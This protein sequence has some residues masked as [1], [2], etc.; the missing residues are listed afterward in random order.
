MKRLHILQLSSHDIA[1]GAERVAYE[2]HQ[3]YGRRGHLSTLAVGQRR[4]KGNTVLEIPND[5]YR[6]KW[7]RAWLWPS[8]ALMPYQS[9]VRGA[10]RLQ[11][12]LFSIGQPKR[13]LQGF[14]GHEDFD[15]PATE[16][17]LG[18]F[19]SKPDV[20]HC[21]NLHGGYFDLRKL[22]DLNREIPIVMTLH[23]TWLLSG[24]CAYSFD[25]G[26]WE[27]GCG[28]C[29]DLTIY[30][31]LKRDATAFNWQRKKDIYRQ[32]RFYLAADSH[33][34]MEKVRRSMLM[35]GIAEAKV[36]HYGIDLSVYRPADIV[37]SRKRLG[38]PQG[39]IVVLFSANGIRNNVFK[40]FETMRRSIAL[41]AQRSR[42]RD[43]VFL[44]VGE[45]APPEKVGEAWVQF[46]PFQR[47]PRDVAAYCQAADIYIH[48]ARE[49]AWG[50]SITEA[51]ACGTPVVATA[52]GGIPEQIK[53]GGTGFLVPKG[54]A[55]AMAT[56]LVRL[57][58]NGEL[59]RRLG[60]TASEDVRIRF[61]LERQTADYLNWY[62]EI[63]ERFKRERT[64]G[65]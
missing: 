56:H 10:V 58:E 50:R 33:W 1:G 22:P 15:F 42:N 38:L 41:A 51:L 16:H 64:Q 30:P 18:L 65:S 25:C 62:T 17:L 6:G 35:A 40:D 26:R 13:W 45:S 7:A 28:Q 61:D 53:D 37:E 43:L 46:V 4:G 57:A 48:A 19:E 5:D 31:P 52:V 60:K 47:N 8:K 9:S 14:K 49:E 3:A 29:P 34:L 44:A 54:D 23:D 55:E 24:H 12:L 20:L 59:R 63:I 11:K 27:T 32:C 2:L 36:I 39:A 21:H